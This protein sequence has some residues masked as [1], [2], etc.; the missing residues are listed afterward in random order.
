[1]TWKPLILV[2]VVVV[3]VVGALA[4]GLGRVGRR[5]HAVR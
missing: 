4:F 1:M 3:G 5:Q 2:V